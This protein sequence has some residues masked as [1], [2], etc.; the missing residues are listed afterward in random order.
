[1]VW[2]K[3]DYDNIP[4]TYVFDG[5]Q[6][7]G[8][9]ELNKLFYSLNSADN[10]AALEADPETYMAKFKL[11]DEQRD[12]LRNN[13]FL[14]VVRKGGNIYYLAKMAIPRGISVQHVGASFQDISVE[15]FRDKLQA[16]ADGMIEKLE[17]AGGYWNG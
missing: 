5:K 9:Y 15:E 11:T 1:M 10:R 16:N 13:D 7:S 12:A 14:E 8:A 2:N 4:G 3:H 6:A 17:K